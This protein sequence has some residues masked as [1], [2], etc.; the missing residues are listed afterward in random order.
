LRY[1]LSG[2]A[3]LSKETQEFLTNALVTVLQG[4]GLTESCGMC[5]ILPPDF[6][7]YGS[8]GVPVPSIEVKLV[9]FP[10]ANYFATNTPPQGEVWIRGNSITKGYFKRDDVTKESFTEDGWF[11]TGDIA[12]WNKDGTLSIIDRKKNLIKLSGGEY[13]AVER[14]EST[15]KS[16]GLVANICVH[17]DSN[18]NRPMAIIFPHEK[19]LEAA[20]QA[21]GIEGKELDVWCHN[22]KVQDLVLKELNAAGKKSGFKPLEL[23]QCVLLTSKEWTPQNG[24]LTAANK[25]QR[26]AILKEYKDEVKKIYP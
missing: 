19:N 26:A 11:K 13:I 9:D 5:A 1:A 14:L 17:A 22:P 2:G 24:L 6:M 12:Q 4:Y 7:Q 21:Q 10:D 3:A 15:Y 20:V 23:L 16:C 8:V 25:L 18:A